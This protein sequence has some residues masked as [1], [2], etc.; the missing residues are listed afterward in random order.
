MDYVEGL[1]YVAIWWEK[2]K[3]PLTRVGAAPKLSNM[4]L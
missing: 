1:H 4:V 3:I 2:R